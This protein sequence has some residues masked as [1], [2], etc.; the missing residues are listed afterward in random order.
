M[1]MREKNVAEPLSTCRRGLRDAA[2]VTVD[3]HGHERV[4]PDAI[5]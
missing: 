3:G 5:G 1:P 2:S 4:S